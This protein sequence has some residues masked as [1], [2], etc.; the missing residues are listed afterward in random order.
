MRYAYVGGRFVR[1]G[2]ACVDVEDRALQFGDAAYEVW[3]VMDGA[4]TASKPH[5]DRLER[6]LGFLDIPPP[7]RRSLNRI[8]LE[9]VR[10]NR[11]RNGLAYLQVTRGTAPRDHGYTRGTLAPTI[12]A[13]AK[14]VN[15]AA[16]DGVAA[17]GVAV[18]THR[19][20]RWDR[21]DLKTT[22]LLPAVLAKQA[23][24]DA[25]AYESWFVTGE[26]EVTEGA[27]TNAFI[28]DDAGRIVTH[29]ATNAILNGVTRQIV[30]DA[31][32]EA[33]V[34]VIERAFSLD[35]AFSAREA[36]ISSASAVLLPVVKIDGRMIAD[37]APGPVA[38]RLRILARERLARSRDAGYL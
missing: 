29:P 30:L 26:G 22:G 5:F 16:Q 19:E 3:M 7:P 14:P 17:R 24:R 27:S 38:Q 10:R 37:G 2:R 11:V 12:I 4:L 36:M 35:E 32:D 6:T 33:R 13:T 34:P 20:I 9:T 21:C 23:A 15:F 1:G 31:A 8:V 28:V 25:G 18:A